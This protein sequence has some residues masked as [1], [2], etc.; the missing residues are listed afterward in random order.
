MTPEL[1]WLT[2]TTALTG[3]LWVPYILNRV[4]EDKKGPIAALMNP[5]VP[6]RPKAAWAERMMRAHVNAVENLVIFA[7]LVLV[8][9][10]VNIST[11]L[12]TEVCCVFFFAR[13]AHAIFYAFR[14]PFLRTVAFLTGFGCQMVLALTLLGGI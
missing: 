5:D 7:V 10:A 1:F 11:V 13:F 2:L 12:T 3:L 6:P 9:H 8:L 14:V 4:L